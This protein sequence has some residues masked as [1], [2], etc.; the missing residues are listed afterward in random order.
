VRI[1][2]WNLAGG[3]V[4]ASLNVQQRN[5][6][7]YMRDELG[8]DVILTQEARK[9]AIP[10]WVTEDWTA[11][12]GEKGRFHKYLPWGSVIAAR[13]GLPLRPYLESFEGPWAL[14]FAHLYDLV[15]IGEIDLPGLG[16]TL[17]ASV[18]AAAFSVADWISRNRLR[19]YS[20]MPFPLKD[21]ELAGLD[22]PGYGGL[23]FINDFAFT[24]LEGLF[25]GKRFFAAGDWNATRKF[26]SGHRSWAGGP[27]FF[28]RAETRGWVECH[29]GTEEQSYFKKGMSG[30]QFDH[31]FCD[32]ETGQLLDSCRVWDND[33]VRALSDHAPLVTD[34]RIPGHKL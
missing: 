21:G 16:P 25:R 10:A 1:V 5:A 30:Y 31:A 13:P 23:P 27:E 14:W 11:V 33:E 8:A 24:A 18:H 17:V 3:S 9:S 32:P 20:E 6:W 19:E 22:R 4:P 29:K 34:L 7:E 12:V 26:D 28:A 15:L 2:S